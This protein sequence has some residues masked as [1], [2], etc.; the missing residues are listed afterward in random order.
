MTNEVQQRPKT[1]IW[2]RCACGEE[3]CKYQYL[4]NL[5]TFYQGTGFTPEEKEW[6]DQAWA[7]LNDQGWQP[8][9]TAPKDG[10]III[11]QGGIAHWHD[12]AWKTLTSY[13][14][15]GRVIQWPVNW[16]MPFPLFSS[17]TTQGESHE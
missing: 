14:W 13:D 17:H 11:V 5:G 8:I 4:T 6:I 15:P 9:E 1:L 2:E 12:G 7:A 10:T 16:W 3:V